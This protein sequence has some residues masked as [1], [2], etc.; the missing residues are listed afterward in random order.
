MNSPSRIAACEHSFSTRNCGLR[1]VIAMR[2]ARR[3]TCYALA[4]LEHRSREID[5]AGKRETRALET[6]GNVDRGPRPV[7]FLM[8]SLDPLSMEPCGLM[9]DERCA[10]HGAQL[11]G[12]AGHEVQPGHRCR[13]AALRGMP[14]RHEIR[15]HLHVSR[16]VSWLDA[17]LSERHGM[18]AC[19]DPL[20]S[21]D[22][23]VVASPRW[24]GHR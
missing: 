10:Q 18:T 15:N 16:P 12:W 11:A 7:N 22:G 4:I 24:G 8:G 9:W 23:M 2:Q 6:I 21:C 17:R 14:N 5:I 13:G 3:A 1:R 19:C 20:L